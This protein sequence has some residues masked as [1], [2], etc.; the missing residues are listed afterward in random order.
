MHTQVYSE[1]LYEIIKPRSAYDIRD[2]ALMAG[3]TLLLIYVAALAYKVSMDK[4]PSSLCVVLTCQWR[5][6]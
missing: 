3:T 6:S 1:N 5:L 4:L 2:C